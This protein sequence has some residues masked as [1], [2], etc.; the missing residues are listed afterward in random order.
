MD[1]KPHLKSLGQIFPV[2]GMAAFAH[3]FENPSI[4]LYHDAVYL[5]GDRHHF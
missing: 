2:E 5:D 4:L 1:L 3:P